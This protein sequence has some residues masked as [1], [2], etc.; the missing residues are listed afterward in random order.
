MADNYFSTNETWK[1]LF[2]VKGLTG[3]EFYSDGCTRLNIE[4]LVHMELKRSGYE[5]IVFYDQEYKLQCYDEESFRLLREG[6]KSAP[7]RASGGAPPKRVKNRGLRRGGLAEK[8][9]GTSA[10]DE[11]EKRAQ[12]ENTPESEGWQAGKNSGINVRA[13]TQESLHMGMQD[14]TFIWRQ[15]KAYIH[16]THIKTA[17][18]IKDASAFFDEFGKEPEH[19]LTAVLERLSADNE[20]I[21]VFIYTDIA[22][23]TPYEV[24]QFGEDEQREQNER[25]AR[26]LKE[27][28]IIN[29]R[30]PCAAEL[31]NMLS[32]F[33]LRYS[34]KL[35]AS[36]L[37]AAALD[38]SRAIHMGKKGD[39]ENRIIRIKELYK[40]LKK[41]AE[42]G[43]ELTPE[44]CYALVGTKKP[45]TAEEQ[46]NELIGMQSVKNALMEYKLADKEVSVGEKEQPW[47]RLVPA[48]QTFKP[49]EQMIHFMLTGNPGTGKTTVA[50]LIGQL[51]YEMG[52]LETGHVVEVSRDKL[53][54]GYVGQTAIK[55]A[56]A[57]EQALGGVLFIDEA[58]TLKR[59]NDT[60]G[61]FGQEAIDTLIKLMDQYKGRFILVAAGYKEE[62]QNFLKSND[63]MQSR[64]TCLHIEDYT[65]TEMQRILE[66]YAKKSNKV[67]SEEFSA[68]LPNFCENWVNLADGKWGNA[69]EA[70]K[71]MD[72]MARKWEKDPERKLVSGAD[73]KE[74]G[75]LETKY[76]PEELAKNLKPVAEMRA[77]AL[78]RLEKLTGL[79]GVKAQVQKLHRSMRAG[80]ITEPGHYIFSGNPGTGKTTVARLMG[81]I[82]RNLG[83][84]KRGHIVE[85]TATQLISEVFNETNMGDFDRVANKALGG[86]LFIDEAYQLHTDSS[87]RGHRILDALVPYMEN[88]R[89]NIS[90]IC[91]GYSDDMDELM[92]YNS[93]FA[94][95]FQKPIF[96]EDYNG[97]ELYTILLA[98]LKEKGIE[99]T[100]EYGERA[101]RVLTGYASVYGK[102]KGFGNA[103]YIRNEFIPSTLDTQTLR[104]INEYGENFPRELK[105]T[106]TG[107]DIPAEMRRFER[108]KIKKA[109]ERSA[110][111]KI[112]DL[113]GFDEIKQHLRELVNLAKIQREQEM[114]DLMDGLNLHW[115][116]RGNP[117]TGK[118]TVAE[119]VGKVYKEIGLLAKGHTIKV[120]RA[121]LVGQYLGDTEQKT[122]KCIENA[123]GGI[124]FIDEAYTLKRE[125]NTGNDYGQIAIDIL[126]EQMSDRKG[127]FA[128]IAAGYPKEMDIFLDSN[129]GFRSRFGEDFL[130]EDYTA[131]ELYRIF[132]IKCKK[133]GFA[134]DDALDRAVMPIF[135]N[136]LKFKT[137]N[138]ANGRE[139]ENLE[140]ELRKK[141]AKSPVIKEENGEKM[142]YYTIAHL[143]KEYSR[144]LLINEEAH[145]TKKNIGKSEGEIPFLSRDELAKGKTG[146]SYESGYLEQKKGIAFITSES[147]DGDSDGSGA[148]IT[149]D[150]Y[151]LTCKHVIDGGG[152]IRVGL[153]PTGKDG[154]AMVWKKAELVWQGNEIDAA[155]IKIDGDGY[156]ALPLRPLGAETQTGENIYIW[157]YP[158]GRNL[159]DD[160]NTLQPNL[161]QGYVSSIQRKEGLER[162]N[163]NME[164]KRGC[165]GGPVF[166][167]KDGNIIGILR[168]SQTIGDEN[169]MEELNYVLP[170]KYIWEVIAE[171]ESGNK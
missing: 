15:I 49:N 152:N 135:E 123:M 79:A 37:D 55:T 36:E 118:T 25:R 144:F 95:R 3:D 38:M 35:R 167:K 18:V 88:N 134:V 67:F 138:W 13:L 24:K 171:K 11:N 6:K 102:R 57:V 119:L 120:T 71:L 86:V 63:G 91:A 34:L 147:A 20:N 142:R 101:L 87:G 7:S 27:A 150:G 116:L 129:P 89:D 159:S 42:A 112:D 76:V 163:L 124:L 94:S 105:K 69:R 53:V 32:Y 111:D 72:V 164:A 5:R 82:L 9:G 33:R 66:L 39:E 19:E 59:E 115:V 131:E 70:V 77:Q 44:G 148:I 125:R 170:V 23:E 26:A 169:L 133:A 48:E 141:W 41:H 97:E 46:L 145:A 81:D 113:I 74:Y 108:T 155:I 16:D 136:M 153:K 50:K 103:R 92:K 56:E 151:I 104:L 106:L 149:R 4:Q 158:F 98:M 85:Y 51:F 110:L 100:E 122:K 96:F 107:G 128:V 17:I 162:I 61:D 10:E 84:L 161:F 160:I 132:K 154:E 99:T 30:C 146:F 54:A 21:I 28:N 22:L 14:N 83:M 117:G 126:L 127:E 43:K 140:T 52:Y 139:T 58:Y 8:N 90:V 73:G 45:K 168:G 80:D 93:G 47:S 40:M 29:V 68:A 165:S 121:D 75:V 2:Y 114:Y 62:M 65:E 60:H 78:A 166:S 157:G 137:K 156:D 31:K 130:L 109:E 12:S 1:H 143:P 64:L